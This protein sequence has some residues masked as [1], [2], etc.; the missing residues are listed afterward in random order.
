ME[1]NTVNEVARMISKRMLLDFNFYLA[2]N[3]NPELAL[4]DVESDKETKKE[5]INLVKK[6]VKKTAEIWGERLG[7]GL[8]NCEGVVYYP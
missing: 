3:Y 1:K 2:F 6:E 8:L 7:C 5:I 4:H